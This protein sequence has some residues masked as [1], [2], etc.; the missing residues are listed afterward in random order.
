VQVDPLGKRYHAGI[1]GLAGL[2]A[3]LDLRPV[4]RA[5]ADPEGPAA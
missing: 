1:N 3:K 5:T 2:L 4:D